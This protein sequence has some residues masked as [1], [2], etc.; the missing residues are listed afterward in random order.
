MAKQDIGLLIADKIKTAIEVKKINV[1][2]MLETLGIPKN[3]FY[4][5]LRNEG[6]Y[7]FKKTLWPI[8][9]YL[10]IKLNEL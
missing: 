1:S 3:S 8:L 5:I 9:E 2:E 6:D 4:R 7:S 10:E